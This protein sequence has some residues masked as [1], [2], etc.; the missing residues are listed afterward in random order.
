MIIPYCGT[1]GEGRMSRKLSMALLTVVVWALTAT[2]A[3]AQGTSTIKAGDAAWQPAEVTVP[4]GTTVRWEFDQTALPHTVTSTSDNWSKNES[5]E[6]GGAAVTHEFTEPGIYTF[7]CDLHGGMD[8]TVTV[9]DDEPFDVLVFSRTTGFRHESAINAGRTAIPQMGAA[10]GFNVQLSEDQTLF[11]D[12]GLRP[13]EVVV[14]LNT[15]GEG[16]LNGA[17]RNAFERWTQRGGGI[18][19]IHADA[20]ADRNWAWKGDMM[21]GAWFLNHPSGAQ[22]FQQATV[23][24]VDTEH[25]AT[26]DLPQPNW[27]RTD[28]WYNFTAEPEDVH[29]L[30]KL[31]ENS[32]DEQD[33]SAAADDHPIAWCS[34][35][36]GGRHFYTALGHEGAYWS[37]PDYLDHIRGAILWAAGAEAGD[38]GDEREGLP[39]DA[40]FDKVTLDDTTENPM[41]IAVAADGDV[42][43]VELAGR[44]KHFDRQTGAVR[45][46]GQIQVH[47]GNENGLLGIALDPDF[48]T[49]RQL[50]LFYS[51]PSP[52]IQRISRFTV[53]QDGTLD[54]GSERRILEFPHQRIICCHSSGSMTF[55]PDGSLYIST[56]DDTQ[57]AESQ[58]YNPIDDRLANEP[59]TNPDADHA[60]DARRSSGNTN[61]L[62]GKILRITPLDDPGET[63]GVGS[64][65]TIPAGN[66]FGLAGKYPGVDGQTRPEIYTM[67]HRNPFR[68]QVDQETGWVYNGE[69]GPD[70]GGENANRGPRGYDE[71]NQIREAGNMGWP[72]CIADNKAYS[73]WDFATQTQSGFFNCSGA[74][75]VNDGPLNDSAWNTGKANTPPTTGAL[76]WWPYQPHANAPNYPWNT[77]PL[78]I[79]QG[80]GRTAIAGP[81]YHFDSANPTDTKFPAWFDDKVFFADW[82]R[83][84]IATLE[85]DEAGMPQEIVEFMPNADFRH[86]QD[87]EMGADGSLYVLEWGRDFNYA[88]S[89]INPDSG[90]YRIDYAKGTRTPVARATADKDSGPTPLTVEFSSEGSEDA[91]GDDL[92][93]SWDFGDGETSTEANPTHTF[94]EAGTYSVRLTATDSTGKSGNSTVVITAGNTRPTVELTVPVQG[95]V[96]DWGDEIP[97]TVTV[98]DPEDGPIDCEDVTVNA[99]VYHDEG[100]NAHVHPGT[101]M[102]GCS[103]TIEAP[104]DSGHEKSA[105]IALVLIA[106]YTDTGGQPGSGPLT[107]ASTRRLTP[108]TIQAEHYTDH[109]GTQ[110]NTVANAEGGRTVGYTDAG[111]FIYFEP[112]SL[113]NI[114]ELRIRYAA[115]E[116]GGFVDVREGAVDGDVIGTAA[117][118]PTA[119]WTD[120]QDVTIPIDPEGTGGRLYFT[121]RA[122]NSAN[123]TDLYDLDEFTF[124]G[125]GVASNSAPT[126]SAQADKLAGPAPLTVSFTGTGADADGD[127]LSYAWDFTNDGTTDATTANATHTYESPGEFTAKFTVSDGERSRS[128]LIEIEAYPPLASCPGNDQFDGTALDTDRWSV[129]RRDDNFL[130]VQGGTLNLNAQPGEDIHGG[131]TGQRNIVLQDLPDSGPWTATAR[132]TWNPTVNFQNAGLVI[133]QDDANWIKSG[134]VWA[135]GRAFE[136]FKELNNNASGLGSATVDASFPSTFYVRFTS[137]GTT[138]RA[139][140]SADG[141]TWTNTGNATNLSGLTNPKVGMYATAS[142]AAGTQANTAR[143]DYFTLDAPQEPSDEFDGSSL[144]L[145]RWSQI[146]RH[147]PGGYTVGGGKLTL[148]AAHGDFFQNAPNNN[149]NILLQP[150][151]SGPWTMTTRLTFNP[152]ENFEQAGLLVYGDD[153]N[154]VKANVVHSGGRG[155]EFLR[156]AN[157]VAAGFGG[158]VNIA[159][160]PTTVDLRITSDGTTLRAYYRFAGGA[161]TQ[162]GEPASLASVPNAK[163]GLY[164]N[165]SNAT[166]T[167]RDDAVFD[168]WRIQAGLPDTTPPSTTRTL[169]PTPLDGWNTTD[170][171]LTLSTEPGAT[172]EYRIGGGAFQTYTGPLTL[173]DEGATTVTYRSTDADGNVEA[174]KSVTV[175]IDKTDPT[176]AATPAGGT[177]SGPFAVSIEASDSGSGVNTVEYRLD[178]GQW[179]PYTEPV[180]IAG[181]GQHTLEHRAYDMAGNAGAATTST[182]TIQ[183]TGAPLFEAFADPSSGSAPLDVRFSADG[184]DPDGG[185]ALRYRWTIDG[186]TVL[187]SSFDWTFTEEG[188]YTVTVTATDDEGTTTTKELQVT[189]TDSGGAAPTVE[190][191]ADRTSGPAPLNVEFSAEGS[192]DVTTYHWDFGDGNGTSLEQN[193][194]HR[195]MT[196]G[197]YTATVTVTDEAGETG[198]DTIVITVTDPPGN[199]APSVDFGVA[200]GS[201]NAPLSVL[202]SPEATDPDDDELSYLWEFGDGDTSTHDGQIRHTY[203]QGGS[204]TAKLTVSDGELT[205][206]KTVTIT[207]GNPPA[208]QA[209]TVQVAADPV[210][211][212]APLDVRFTASGRDPEG[213]ALMYTWDY[214]DG[215]AGAGRS[216][217]HRYLTSGTYTATVTVKDAQGATGTATVVVTVDPQTEGRVRSSQSELVVPSSVRSFRAR[218]MRLIMSCEASG[219]GRATLRVTRAASK[220]LK[221]KSPTVVSRRLTCK[222]GRELSLRLKPNRSTARRLAKSKARALR[223][224]L[225]VSVKGRGT[226]QRK[227]TIR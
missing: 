15:D 129:V 134:M 152:N 130:S 128:V 45:A 176:T 170:V 175:Q 90:L 151:P 206:S 61:D 50:Y 133:Y 56:G 213:G 220:R 145:C 217:T 79:P 211:G 221:L 72:Y 127:T 64:T 108:K 136:A 119:S 116:D 30:L 25:P 11:T 66:L 169:T 114:D 41:E 77:P 198:T 126:A 188:V 207:V 4:T 44:V 39:T 43:Y 17:Q 159:T 212:T 132:V 105:N 111:E 71:L 35:Y 22:Q 199:R 203:R 102:S 36:D 227:V 29:V 82:S 59:G 141:Q 163:V 173:S 156:E 185:P 55:G 118:P 115:G 65:Y 40:S 52:E 63:P 122:M 186:G 58:G 154:Y 67:G 34:N 19:S 100:G 75:G 6:P 147:E 183:S 187:G 69:V 33:G 172:T 14:F 222:A 162:Y 46:I 161:W 219:N 171:T 167:S 140:R 226:L 201:G 88:G 110:S 27:V 223:M 155:L 91:D 216:V 112:V 107:G 38:C 101:D 193:P 148:P 51:A 121:F 20:N 144:D 204:Y 181:D 157:N 143:F 215:S 202:F 93:F 109:V 146:V 125:K 164:A 191:S 53:A 74:G 94:D 9:E 166:V 168:F 158:F 189:V 7:R 103:G 195:Y 37:E 24:V 85:L 21:G 225:S 70:A 224:T 47:R 13:F 89:G 48:A 81:I 165:D 54:M 42:Y 3:H 184:I 73:N 5:R 192:D 150:A 86:P 32:Y 23:N 78:A 131:A 98:T 138:V 200:P 208:N 92:T 123:P 97:Y 179:A 10:E 214:G 182:Y 120:F 26:R 190:A 153:A 210:R 8:G 62:R 135:N 49:N 174:D 177:F 96:F 99:G 218:G 209:P 139:Q 104:A 57:H 197:T 180:T 80:P 12:A 106:N 16:I 2:A 31:D 124:I 160:Q 18:V 87:I 113:V 194:T 205:A 76:L 117:L 83:D 60:R 137:D 149:P 28:E 1:K 68:I 196:P 142:T 95:G 84:W 178:G